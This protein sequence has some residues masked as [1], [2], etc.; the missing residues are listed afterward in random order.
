MNRFSTAIKHVPGV[1]MNLPV[2]VLSSTIDRKMGA[3]GPKFQHKIGSELLFEHQLR[4]IKSK[5]P[6]SD[7]IL[8]IGNGNTVAERKLREEWEKDGVKLIE[9][10]MWKDTSEMETLRLT[11]NI[12]PN[13]SSILVVMGDLY[14]DINSLNFLE[15]GRSSI[16]YNVEESGEIGLSFDPDKDN[17]L[18]GIGFDLNAKWSGIAYFTGRELEL[19]RKFCGPR[20]SRMEMWEF[21]KYVIKY[22]GNVKCHPCCGL[23]KRLNTSQ[24]LGEV[25][26][27]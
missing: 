1:T 20:N 12:L 15:F 7:V 24:K 23:A 6:K 21:F 11:L 25:C 19:L 27:G 10:P 26:D 8:G 3:Y 16:I 4:V 17:K 5:F 14:F 22:F 2:A 18:S 9:N 13:L